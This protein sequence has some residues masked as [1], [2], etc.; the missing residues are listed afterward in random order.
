MHV[1]SAGGMRMCAGCGRG[2]MRVM[3]NGRIESMLVF[4][5]AGLTHGR[6]K[7]LHREGKGKQPQDHYP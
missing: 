2:G 7:A 1:E 3:Y 4:P 5:A 6:G